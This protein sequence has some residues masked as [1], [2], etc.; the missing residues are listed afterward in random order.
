LVAGEEAEPDS[1]IIGLNRV[2]LDAEQREIRG[3]PDRLNAGG[4]V[5]IS[6]TRRCAKHAR[7]DPLNLFFALLEA[8]P[9]LPAL[10]TTPS[11]V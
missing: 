9:L 10:Q 11:R 2:F 3:G 6:A 1:L 8:A 5:A 7:L 4:G